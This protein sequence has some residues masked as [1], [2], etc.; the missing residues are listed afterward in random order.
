MRTLE[1]ASHEMSQSNGQANA[2][3]TAAEM[4]ALQNLVNGLQTL[5][6]QMQPL[7]MATRAPEPP[8]PPP[9]GLLQRLPPELRTMIYEFAV[10]SPRP[11]KALMASSFEE[12]ATEHGKKEAY[13]TRIRPSQPALALVDRQTRTEVLPIFYSR[14]AFLFGPNLTHLPFK[15][16]VSNLSANTEAHLTTVIL[17][18]RVPICHTNRQAAGHGHIFQVRLSKQPGK[19]LDIQFQHAAATACPCDLLDACHNYPS[20]DRWHDGRWLSR[21]AQD[22]EWHT[23]HNFS[24][25]NC[26]FDRELRTCDICGKLRGGQSVGKTILTAYKYRG[27]W[28]GLQEELNRTFPRAT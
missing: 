21:T 10:A 18:K 3:P 8:P 19:V 7:G 24:Y 4:A 2:N 17:M 16:W 28:K 27:D 1:I 9:N 13:V 14:N 15:L 20:E 22:V 5:A 12:I 23:L 25:K 26:P 6:A 11:L